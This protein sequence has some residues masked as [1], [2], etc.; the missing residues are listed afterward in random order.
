MLRQG[1][2]KEAFLREV[3]RKQHR[4]QNIVRLIWTLSREG[5]WNG[6]VLDSKGNTDVFPAAFT[7]ILLKG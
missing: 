1:K 6:Q 5:Q 2:A 7:L 4:N 3:I